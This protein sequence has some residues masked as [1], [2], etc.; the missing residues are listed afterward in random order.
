MKQKEKAKRI[1]QWQLKQTVSTE[2]IKMLWT[3]IKAILKK[4]EGI[5][6]GDSE[7][8]IVLQGMLYAMSLDVPV[9]VSSNPRVYRLYKDSSEPSKWNKC[10]AELST[11]MKKIKNEFKTFYA[12]PP[13]VEL[14]KWME[15]ECWRY[16]RK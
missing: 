13:P 5:G 12:A 9:Q 6:C 16:C 8:E 14:M 15:V 10:A 1:A 2:R 3:E 7:P 4:Y 11:V